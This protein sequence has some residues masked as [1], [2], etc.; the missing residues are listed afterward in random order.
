MGRSLGRT[1]EHEGEGVKLSVE[2]G[3]LGMQNSEQ[4]GQQLV[5]TCLTG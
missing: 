5:Q 1:K 4:P 2:S 3:G